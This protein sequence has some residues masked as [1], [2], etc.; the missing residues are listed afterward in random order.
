MEPGADATSGGPADTMGEEPRCGDGQ[1]DPGEECDDP[2]DPS[3]RTCLKDRLVF[4]TSES[5]PGDFAGAAALEYLCNHLADAAGL[6]VDHKP[7]FLPWLSTKRS[8]ATDRLHHARGRYVLRNGLVLADSW[9]ALV[10]GELQ[11]PPSIDENGELLEVGVWT[12]TRPDGTR[13]PQ[14]TQCNDWTESDFDVTGSW[15]YSARLDA[16]WTQWADS[17]VALTSCGG[18]LSLYCFEQH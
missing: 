17:E 7:R 4:V 3:C 10:A 11:N 6:L 5:V 13:V 8:G 9:D 16:E 15:G 12:G 2:E 18:S 1:I 14:S